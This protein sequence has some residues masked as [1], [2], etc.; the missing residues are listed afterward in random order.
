MLGKMMGALVLTLGL[1]LTSACATTGNGGGC[2]GAPMGG[3]CG[4]APM[5]GGCG[6]GVSSAEKAEY[7]NVAMVAFHADWCGTCKR[8][9]PTVMETAAKVGTFH[10]FD[11]TNDD[12]TKKSRELAMELGM[13]KAYEEFTPGTGFVVVFSKNHPDKYEMLKGSENA[14]EYE[15]LFRKYKFR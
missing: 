1:G 3:G 10:K 11:F 9:G 7:P 2:G 5:G 4:G 15:A 8:I 6:G 12:T 13:S 14:S